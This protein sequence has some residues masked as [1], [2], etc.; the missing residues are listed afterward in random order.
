MAQTVGYMIA[1]YV[2]IFVGLIGYLASL[3]IRTRNLHQDENLLKELEKK[4]K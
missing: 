3:V 4:Q 1:G 2:V